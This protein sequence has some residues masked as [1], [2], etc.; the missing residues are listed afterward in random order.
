MIENLLFFLSFVV[1]PLAT[2]FLLFSVG[3]GVLFW[4]WKLFLIALST[5][6]VAIFSHLVVGIFAD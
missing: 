2:I 1:M 6:F 5:F 4:D 3:Y